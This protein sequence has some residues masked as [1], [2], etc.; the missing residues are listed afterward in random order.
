M[1]SFLGSIFYYDNIGYGH[2][3][4]SKSGRPNI[5]SGYPNYTYSYHT[6]NNIEEC[7]EK[8]SSNNLPCEYI[9][10]DRT[11]GLC[12]LRD[13]SCK[14]VYSGLPQPPRPPKTS[15]AIYKKMQTGRFRLQGSVHL[16]RDTC[17]S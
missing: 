7:K 10:Y 12:H 2:H 9:E 13:N 8:C 11:E 16:S 3:C 15:Y 1:Y 17:F 14:S 5:I 4:E 6:T